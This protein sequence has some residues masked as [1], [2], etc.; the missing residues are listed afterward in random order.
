VTSQRSI[1]SLRCMFGSYTTDSV[2]ITTARAF[3]AGGVS[4]FANPV[5][6][7][8]GLAFG[9]PLSHFVCALYCCQDSRVQEETFEKFW[10]DCVLKIRNIGI[11]EM[12]VNKQLVNL[13]RVAFLAMMSY[14]DGV[15]RLPL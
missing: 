9:T 7:S 4:L 6:V 2:W 15:F 12:T 13:Q 10:E 11:P 8:G 3:I 5:L 14:D 1:P